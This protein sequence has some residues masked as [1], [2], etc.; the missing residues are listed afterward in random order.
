MTVWVIQQPVP[1][2]Q[3]WMPD[4]SSAIEYGEIQYIFGANEKVY[5]LP[6]PS[7][8]KARKLLRERFNSEK[9]YVLWPNTGD[10]MACIIACMVLGEMEFDDVK[11][12]YWNR[13]RDED[14][15]R[16]SKSGF[17][18]PINV[19]LNE[20]KEIKDDFTGAN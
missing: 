17:Y 10:P 3:G 2:R 4:F 11:C 18:F 8:F 9:D 6:G 14:G 1:N 15:N 19:S 20:K 5:A 12:L 16:D 13:K 7:L